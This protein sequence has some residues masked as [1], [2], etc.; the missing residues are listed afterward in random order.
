MWRPTLGAA[1][2]LL[3]ANGAAAAVFSEG[4]G[5]K[6]VDNY[7]DGAEPDMED[8]LKE[9]YLIE[10]EAGG[11]KCSGSRAEVGNKTRGTVDDVRN[12]R[13]LLPRR[14]ALT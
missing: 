7:K 2:I 3:L 10:A 5:P 4:G 13:V 14:R 11:L 12:D 9:K 1:L 6:K 8:H